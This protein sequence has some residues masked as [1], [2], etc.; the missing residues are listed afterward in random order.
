VPGID[1]TSAGQ[2]LNLKVTLW[3]LDDLKETST[4]AGM[5]HGVFAT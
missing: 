4:V 3:R 5:G 2:K 1:A